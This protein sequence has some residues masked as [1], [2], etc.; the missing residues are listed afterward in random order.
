MTGRQPVRCTEGHFLRPSV[1]QASGS[2][3]DCYIEGVTGPEYDRKTGCDMHKW[4]LAETISGTGIRQRE[5]DCYI[6]GV[7]GP[8]YG[9]KTGCEMDRGSFVETICGTGIRQRGRQLY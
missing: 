2:E 5:E 8:E 3:E 6:E 4:S 1:G 7:T 9:R